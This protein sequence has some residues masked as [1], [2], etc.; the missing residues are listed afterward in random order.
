MGTGISESEGRV[1]GGGPVVVG[2]DGSELAGRA[3]PV[4]AVMARARGTAL[5]VVRVAPKAVTADLFNVALD[6]HSQTQEHAEAELRHVISAVRAAFPDLDVRE[7]LANGSPS[8]ELLRV[9]EETG[10][11]V[12]VLTSHGRTALAR[13]FRG[14]VTDDVVRGSHCPALVLW[15]WALP[16]VGPGQIGR[17][18]V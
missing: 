1:S 18:H 4:A 6:D 16:D 15:P 13:T 9:Q 17:A 11:S 7:V 12:V 2:I 3:V 10:A 14:S 5:V 8:R